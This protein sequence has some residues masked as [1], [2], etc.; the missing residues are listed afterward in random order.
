MCYDEG[1]GHTTGRVTEVRLEAGGHMEA[2]IACP[3]GAIPEAG[4]YT[5]ASDPDDREAPLGVPVFLAKKS[6]QGFWACSPMALPWRPGTRLDLSGPLGHG[7]V[8][9]RDTQRL[10]LVALG[11]TPTRLMPLVH[12]VSSRHTGVTLFTDLPL[13]SMPASLEAY[14]FSS[15]A[16][17]LDWPD[18]MAID[19]PL[20]SLPE[21]RA[22][23]RIRDGNR[24]P[25]PAQVLITT[26]MPCAGLAR[27]GVCAV[28]SVRGYKLACEDGPI[29]D[30]ST[31][32][33]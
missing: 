7:F 27:C 22:L 16:D 18:F 17:A 10:G 19:L 21:L 14:P 12:Q 23:L 2:L 8:L 13:P 25:F 3:A 4:Q 5:L 30:L 9:P 11:E 20:D 32:K 28:P 26:P 1:M 29:F 33:W 6:T 24:L 15:L 31:L